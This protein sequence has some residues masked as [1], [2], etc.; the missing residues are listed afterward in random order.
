MPLPIL[1]AAS[2]SLIYAG[3]KPYRGLKMTKQT[4][5]LSIRTNKEPTVR[6]SNLM[7]NQPA[8]NNLQV[9]N[10]SDINAILRR[11]ADR[12]FTISSVSLALTT[13]GALFYPPLSLLG[14]AGIAY[15]SVPLLKKGYHS[16][17]KKRKVDMAVIDLVAL[18]G[19]LL[20]GYYFIAAVAYWFYTLSQKLLLKIEDQSVKSLINVFGEQPNSIWVLINDVEMEIPF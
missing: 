11:H 12:D 18:P 1:I 6:P 17:F 5:S 3:V 15:I 2:S 9:T 14:M 19:L 10:D 7:P 4:R 16:L 20:A 8:G 13:V